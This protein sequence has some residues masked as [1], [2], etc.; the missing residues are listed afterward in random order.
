MSVDSFIPE[1]WVAELLESLRKRLVYGQAGIVNRNYEGQISQQGDTVKI[2]SIGRPTVQNYVKNSTT[3][4]P[5]QLTSAQQSLL[6]DQAKYFAFEVDDIDLA[7][8]A[9]GG[10]L[11]AGGISEAAFAL[12]D[13]ADQFIAG[14]YTGVAAA[15]NL[16]TVSVTTAAL[17]YTQLRRLMV[18]LDDA[19]VPMEGRW[20]VVPNW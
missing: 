18:A 3:I 17:A 14:L 16:G 4:T 20:V 7:Q 5:E 6:I 2:N 12:R 13:V 10:G 15:N 9:N 1:I 19:N 8:T 11:M